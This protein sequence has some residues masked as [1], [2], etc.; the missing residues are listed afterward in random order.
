MKICFKC[1]KELPH[2]SFYKH[3]QMPD[4]HL[5]KCIECF[6]AEMRERYDQKCKD[7]EWLKKERERGREKYR[8]LGYAARATERKITKQNKFR[9]MKDVRRDIESCLSRD[10]EL[11]HWDYNQRYN[12]ILLD[13]K[14][15]HRLHSVIE[16]NM[17]EGIYYYNGGKLDTIEKHLAVIKQVCEDQGFKYSD[18]ILIQKLAV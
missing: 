6:K 3:P 1:G 13:K 18:V 7:P 4:G 15:H 12:L 10:K 14:L 2:S 16:L 11:H 9:C 5:N 8:R 17:E